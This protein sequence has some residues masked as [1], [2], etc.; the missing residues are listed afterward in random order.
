[1]VCGSIAGEVVASHVL[2]GGPLSEFDGAWRAEMGET[3]ENSLRIRRMSDVVFKNA[4]MID[5]VTKRGWLTE[6]MIEKFILCEMD[7]KMRLVEKSL[8]LIGLE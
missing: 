3:L 6:E 1:M 7:L 4:R 5:W 2:E 8:G